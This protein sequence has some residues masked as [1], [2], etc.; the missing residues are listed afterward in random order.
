[1]QDISNYVLIVIMIGWCIVDPI[2]KAIITISKS[3]KED[4]E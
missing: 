2:C 1:M 4:K 3:K